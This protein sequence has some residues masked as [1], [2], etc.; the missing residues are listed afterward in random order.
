TFTSRDTATLNPDPSVQ[1]NRYTYANASPLTHTDPTGHSSYEALQNAGSRPS[2]DWT[3]N[4]PEVIPG[5]PYY[6]WPDQPGGLYPQFNEGEEMWWEERYGDYALRPQITDEEA[7][8]WGIMPTGRPMPKDMEEEFWKASEDARKEFLVLYNV[9]QM[10]NTEVTNDDIVVQ[11]IRLNPP[12]NSPASPGA[13]P[14]ASSGG[15]GG[16]AACARLYSKKACQEWRDAAVKAAALQ[17][18]REECSQIPAGKGAADK[19]HACTNLIQ[20]AGMTTA[21]WWALIKDK[22][23]KSLLFQTIDLLAGDAMACRDG[24]FVSCI[25][26]VSDIA[27]GPASKGIKAL[28][29]KLGVAGTVFAKAARACSSFL[30]GTKVLMAD[31]SLKSIEKVKIGDSIIAADPNARKSE[32]QLV[33]ALITSLG[34]KHL[35]R[36]QVDVDGNNGD[37]LGQVTATTEHPIWAV[38]Q[39]RWVDAGNLA[40]G[41]I[42]LSAEGKKL[43]LV[44]TYRYTQDKQRVHNLT[45]ERSHTYHVA[46]GTANLLVHNASPCSKMVSKIGDDPYLIK[47]AEEAGRSSQKGMDQLFDQLLRGN[48]NP[49][50]GSEALKGTDVMYARHR[51]G[52][53]MFF[54]KVGDTIVIVGKAD[55]RNESKVIA[56][57]EKL[58]GQ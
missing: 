9:M 44:S 24:D 1:A 58:Y 30:P 3:F 29:K 57:L 41:A 48:M 10:Y 42:L 31:G 49:G 46:A 54:R 52:A 39:K 35:V 12:T 7:K 37:K 56:R 32:K 43:K 11:W 50:I 55:K 53:R 16:W 2:S 14:Q 51:N 34:V 20:M 45:V 19:L 38:D 26:M 17:G 18:A 5:Q 27:G 21:D 28:G 40:A 22:A 23:K 6:S 13:P 4:A 15:N 33:T 36:L 25:L 47:A 8:K